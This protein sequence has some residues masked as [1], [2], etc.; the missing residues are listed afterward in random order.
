[1][2]PISIAH[3]AGS[4]KWDLRAQL[5]HD[6]AIR[7][8]LAD[9]CHSVA[10][11]SDAARPCLS[12]QGW[13]RSLSYDAAK[14]LTEDTSEGRGHVR[15]SSRDLYFLLPKTAARSIIRQELSSSNERPPSAHE[16]EATT[17]D[18]EDEAVVVSSDESR[19]VD[20]TLRLLPWPVVSINGG[21][22]VEFAAD[23]F[24]E[25]RRVWEE[26]NCKSVRSEKQYNESIRSCMHALQPVLVNVWDAC[27]AERLEELWRQQS[28]ASTFEGLR[29]RMTASFEHHA[30]G[31]EM[32]L[33][34]S[35]V[36]PE[37]HGLTVTVKV[38]WSEEWEDTYAKAVVTSVS[39]TA[40]WLMGIPTAA[41]PAKDSVCISVRLEWSA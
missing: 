39:G 24:T 20:A 14:A 1:M 4:S 17:C 19:L 25:T 36:F 38:C 15:P 2:D 3:L 27:V 12:A 37:L 32:V 30:A 10:S 28:Q 35:R 41:Q 13:S 6:P 21:P 26:V 33:S 23:F 8:A 5:L 34:V 16:E 11:S 40:A 7:D 9:A 29:S 18:V 22:A 31:V